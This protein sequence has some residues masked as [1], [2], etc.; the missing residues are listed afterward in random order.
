MDVSVYGNNLISD[1]FCLNCISIHKTMYAAESRMLHASSLLVANYQPMNGKSLCDLD[2]NDYLTGSTT[3]A[4]S[5]NALLLC[6]NS[7]AV[8]IRP[9]FVIVT[10]TRG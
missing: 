7:R 4:L 6:S 3:L 5:S 2:A 8:A 10:W 1:G 9:R